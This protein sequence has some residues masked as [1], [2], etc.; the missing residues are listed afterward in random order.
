MNMKKVLL[1]LMVAFMVC[2]IFVGA[3]RQVGVSDSNM[4]SRAEADRMVQE[5]VKQTEIDVRRQ[6]DK[7]DSK[8]KEE[9]TAKTEETNASEE[10]SAPAEETAPAETAEENKTYYSFT[11]I[12]SDLNMRQEP[13]SKSKILG[14]LKKGT[15]GYL[16]EQGEEFSLCAADNKICY[17]S[18]KYLE[19]KEVTAE[20]YPKELIG[21]TAEDVGKSIEELG[22]ASEGAQASETTTEQTPAEGNAATDTTGNSGN[23]E[24]PTQTTEA[25]VTEK[26]NNYANGN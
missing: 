6:M 18:N 23:T 8:A 11:V 19:M 5:A 10:Q 1:F 7:E 16:I 12:N 2:G 21:V 22:G 9:T 4:V 15:T 26:L 3:Y 17:L 13:N 20:E 24:Q 14:R 25:E